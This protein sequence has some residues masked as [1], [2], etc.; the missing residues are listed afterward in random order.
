MARRPI[1]DVVTRVILGV[2]LAGEI[3]VGLTFLATADGRRDD[4]VTRFF[5]I[6]T[7]SGEPYRDFQVEYT[8]LQTVLIEQLAGETVEDTYRRVVIL[9]VLLH[10]ATFVIML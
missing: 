2:L 9:A 8:P 1:A 5:E 6:A 3:A 4:D 7:R 10:T